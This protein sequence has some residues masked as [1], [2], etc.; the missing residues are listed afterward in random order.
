MLDNDTFKNQGNKEVLLDKYVIIGLNVFVIF[1]INLLFNY[2]ICAG[3]RVFYDDDL[4]CINNFLNSG[5]ILAFTFSLGANKLRPASYLVIALVLRLAGNNYEIID[6]ALLLLNFVNAILIYRFIYAIQC[7]ENVMRKSVMALVGS[8]LFI[9]SRF[10]YYNISEVLGLMEG[11]GLAFSILVLMSLYS[12]LNI[13][14]DKYIIGATIFY[15]LAIYSHERYFLLFICFIVT[16]LFKKSDAI[17]KKFSIILPASAI[18]LSFW[19]I[20][21]ILFGNRAIDGTGGTS[22]SET[23]NFANVIKFCFSQVGYILGFN[24]G[25]QYLNGIEAGQVP[26]IINIF[27]IFNLLC[28][29]SVVILYARLLIKYKQFR[30][31]NLKNIILFITFIAMCII[32]SSTTIRVEMRWIFISYAVYVI[33]LFYMMDGVMKYYLINVKVLLI[34]A[35]YLISILMTEQFYRGNYHNL[36][37]WNT[38][39]MTRELYDITVDR[40]GDKLLDKDI[41][42]VSE[43]KF[44]SNWEAE[45]WTKFFRPYIDADGINVC[46]VDGVRSAEELMTSM[47]SGA[48]VLSEDVTNKSYTDITNCMSTSYYLLSINNLYGIYDDWWCEP[49][50]KFEVLGY[51]NK[52]KL[53]FYY[54]GEQEIIGNASGKVIVNGE[55]E[56]DFTLTGNMT[57]VEIPLSENYNNTIQIISDYWVYEHTDRSEDG[58]LSCVLTVQLAH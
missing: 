3:N 5:G 34:F 26:T 23:F 21:I 40:Y 15:A 7:K 49:D 28:V 4:S 16:A 6:E 36:Y 13:G 22:I 14:G 41:I 48:I 46:Y 57:S 11:V 31:E 30:S 43:R 53:L 56:T 24:C 29:L 35:F 18:L 50:C 55:M 27:L 8:L 19:V 58:R 20:R 52:M 2:W 38:K 39:D 42:I 9:A 25:P 32:S 33:L 1:L 44:F 10:A 45:E 51:N 12:Y 47:K 17:L 37:Y 54:P